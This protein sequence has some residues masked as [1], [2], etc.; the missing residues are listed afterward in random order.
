MSPY[1]IFDVRE[2]LVSLCSKYIAG[3]TRKQRGKK[4]PSNHID[5]QTKNH[6]EP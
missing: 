4:L 2:A 1:C 5:K 3:T 6:H